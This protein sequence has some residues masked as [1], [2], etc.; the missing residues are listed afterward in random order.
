MFII[1]GDGICIV[2][3]FDGVVDKFVLLLFNFIGIDLYMWDVSVLS[4]VEYFYVLCYDVCGYGVLDVLVGV[5][6]MDWFGCDVVELFDV[7]GI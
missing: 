1:I 7:L 4:L 6:L 3:C 5:Y 2:Y